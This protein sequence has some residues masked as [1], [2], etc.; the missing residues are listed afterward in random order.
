V[1]ASAVFPASSKLPPCTVTNPENVLLPWSM[2]LPAPVFCRPA[3][4]LRLPLIVVSPDPETVNEFPSVATLPLTV[5]MEKALFVP[6]WS[7]ASTV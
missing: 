2:S 5:A 1:S 7:V 3:V 4:P 6:L